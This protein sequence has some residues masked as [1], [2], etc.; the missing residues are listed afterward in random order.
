MRFRDRIEGGRKLVAPLAELALVDPVVLALPRGG[1]PVAREVAD[2]LGVPF[3][4]LVVRKVGAPGRPE[5]GMGAVAEGGGEV[6]HGGA[7]RALGV[8]E[9]EFAERADA[10]RGELDRRV[11]VYRGDRDLPALAGRDVVVVDDGL[12]T[13]VTA[14]AALQAVRRQAP[15][16]LVLAVPVGAADTV[17]RLGEVADH[18]VCVLAPTDFRAVGHWYDRFDQ[19]SD[20]EVLAALDRR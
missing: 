9:A 20:A 17:T 7:V 19:T 6:V 18:V 12:A 15:R 5:Y 10:E 11:A 2:G 14:E 4:V 8:S 3:D 16:R 13:G 1:V